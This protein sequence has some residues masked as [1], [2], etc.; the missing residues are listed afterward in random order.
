MAYIRM[1]GEYIPPEPKI[2]GAEWD[3]SSSPAWTRTDDAVGLA[4]PSPAVNNGDGSSPFDEIMP[5]AGMRRVEDSEAGTLV[6]IPKFWYKWTRNNA[7]MKLQISPTEVDGFFVSPAHA[8]RGDGA[9]ERDVV[10]VGAY[11]CDINYFKSTTG[12][13][14]N[15]SYQRSHFRTYIHILG[16]TI[17]QWD[18][19]MY[20]TIMMLY[21]VEYANWNSQA[22]IG[23]GC[24][25][26]GNIQKNGLCD[27]MT[28]HTG[29]NASSRTTY[30]HTR[31]RYIE[32]LWGNV[33]DICD[34][35]YFNS[36]NNIYCIKNPANFSN[37][38]GGTLV[39]TRASS[40]GYPTAWTNPT[41]S[42]FEYALYPSAAGGSESTYVCDHCNNYNTGTALYIGGDMSQYQMYGAFYMSSTF[43]DSVQST[44]IGSRL[45]KLP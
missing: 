28:Y 11:H 22:M 25:D 38:S 12:I 1:S 27:N 41:A 3:G 32:D 42:G 2:Y 19:A 33:F 45:M 8:D 14:P 44:G 18:F 39:G 6:E 35:I 4:S 16:S 31:Y 26:S 40:G 17:W 30:G 34:G 21:L 43:A 10:Y 9:G 13:Q 15:S 37:T 20:W 5:W 23:Y 24:S 29:T 7:A 36:S